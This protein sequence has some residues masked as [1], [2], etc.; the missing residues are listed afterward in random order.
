[1]EEAKMQ[2]IAPGAE[3]LMTTVPCDSRKKK[4][5]VGLDTFLMPDC[6]PHTATEMALLVWEQSGWWAELAL[7][8]FF[9]HSQWRSHPWVGPK[10]DTN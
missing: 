3:L 5:T 8:E 2:K 6:V 4:N 10:Q 9:C 7:W 1:M